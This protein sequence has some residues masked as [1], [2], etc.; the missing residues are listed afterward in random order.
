MNE[1]FDFD[2]TQSKSS[3][4]PMQMWDIL[5]ILV[6][7]LTVCLVGYFALIF[8]NPASSLNL[9]PPGGGLFN[10][11]LPTPTVTALQMEPTWTSSPTLA[12]T[13][14]DTPRPTITALF[15]NTPFSL[16]PPTKTPRPSATPTTPKA[17]FSVTVNYIQ[18]TIFYPEL[19]CSNFIVGGEAVDD[20]NGP[21]KF[22]IV[23]VGGTLNGQTIDPELH[24]TVTGV[25]PQFGSAGFEIKITE[26]PMVDSNGTLWIQM[27]HTDGSPLSD[28]KFLNTYNDCDRNLIQVRFKAN[29]PIQ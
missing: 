3:Q 23:K 18:S 2:G 1:D 24:T 26:V 15:T 6:L 22:G 14:S 20:K 21:Y 12:V 28:R 8:I 11:P 29:R 9:L 10:E 5:S 17:P 19:T 27:V 25:A 4:A 16:V 7:I 13:P